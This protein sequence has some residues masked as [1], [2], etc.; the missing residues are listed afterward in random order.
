MLPSRQSLG[1]DLG[2]MTL[3]SIEN[4]KSVNEV[5]TPMEIVVL[6][7]TPY[8]NCS[9]VFVWKAGQSSSQFL[10]QEVLTPISAQRHSGDTTSQSFLVE[11]IYNTVHALAVAVHGNEHQR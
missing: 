11:P 5:L 1:Q 7:R 3:F 6:N 2:H 4:L 9:G 10:E 8:P